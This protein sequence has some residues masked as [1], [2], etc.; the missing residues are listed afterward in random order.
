MRTDNIGFLFAG[1][2]AQSVGMGRDFYATYPAVRELHDSIG[3]DVD[4]K[5]LCFNGPQSRLNQTE[6]AQPAILLTSIAIASALDTH[7]IFPRMVAGFS[8]GEYS[9]LTYAKALDFNRSLHLVVLRGK[10]MSRVLQGKDTA[11]LA[12]INLKP[13]IVVDIVDQANAVGICDIAS[14]N[15]P[16]QIVISG[17]TKA[18][19]VAQRLAKK[20]KGLAIPVNVSGAFHSRC[21]LEA[22]EPLR[23][24]LEVE[25]F[26]HPS[27]ELVR[28]LTGTIETSDP[29]ETLVK[30][31]TSTVKFE[32]SIR[33]MIRHGIRTFIEIGPGTVLAGFVRKID[34]TVEVFSVHSVE[35]LRRL[36][37]GMK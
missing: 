34:P 21:L 3:L 14:I 15:C 16:E 5:D 6:Y 20:H 27:I 36:V 28:N 4:L 9:A 33:T 17:E 23:K 25:S 26:R 37:E 32:A 11:M 8:L 7:G 2:G 31:M 1:Q 12:L 29:I 10:L 19:D 22:E 13:E 30:H 35:S 24:I 18:L